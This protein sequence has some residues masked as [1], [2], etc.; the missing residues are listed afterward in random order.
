MSDQA[1]MLLSHFMGAQ[2]GGEANGA[3]TIAQ[4]EPLL[5]EDETVEFATRGE[6]GGA[7]FTSLRLIIVNEAGLFTKRSVISFI[8]TASIDAV[9]IDDDTLFQVKLTGRGFGGA[10][11]FFAPDIDKIKVTRWFS[12]A[13]TQP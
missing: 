1:S 11:L 3:E 8:R 12:N 7:V 10:Y 6:S 5:L 9:S 2:L 13:V 4:V